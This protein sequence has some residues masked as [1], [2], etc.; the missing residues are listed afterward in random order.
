MEDAPEGLRQP[1]ARYNSG[2]VGQVSEARKNSRKCLSCPHHDSLLS[3]IKPLT[4][5][6]PTK[7]LLAGKLDSFNIVTTF[8]HD[9]I[10]TRLTVSL[11]FQRGDI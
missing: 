1:I 2:K 5:A 6:L 4:A 10:T 3:L 8:K 11:L 7:R 9:D